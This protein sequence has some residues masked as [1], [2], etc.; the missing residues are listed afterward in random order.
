MARALP[1]R[2]FRADC[3]NLILR[4][5]GLC[6]AELTDDA[7]F[8]EE[9]FTCCSEGPAGRDPA[10]RAGTGPPESDQPCES[11]G[12][13]VKVV[14]QDGPLTPSKRTEWKKS[15]NGV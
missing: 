10:G 11:A 14:R 3:V 6:H 5:A 12:E 13:P 15:R 4:T 1:T 8:S 9:M 7:T 2:C